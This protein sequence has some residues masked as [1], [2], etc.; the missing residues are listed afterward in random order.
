MRMGE[1]ISLPEDNSARSQWSKEKEEI[2]QREKKR[3][4]TRIQYL[5]DHTYVLTHDT[6]SKA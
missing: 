2:K 6:G 5:K 4:R 3:F 1:Q